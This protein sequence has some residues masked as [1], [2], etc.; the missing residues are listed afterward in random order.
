MTQNGILEY[1]HVADNFSAALFWSGSAYTLHG[2]DMGT[3]SSLS[4]NGRPISFCQTDSSYNCYVVLVIYYG[5]RGFRQLARELSSTALGWISSVLTIALPHICYQRG[6]WA[7]GGTIEYRRDLCVIHPPLMMTQSWAKST[8][9][10]TKYGRFINQ[11]PPNIIKSIRQFERANKK[12]FIMFNQI[13]IYRCVCVC[14]CVCV[15]VCVGC[16]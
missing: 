7:V 9:E 14:L 13:Y 2:R 12:M 15:C 1:I 5:K 11:F 4:R 8:L 3:N 6:Q 10:I 16:H